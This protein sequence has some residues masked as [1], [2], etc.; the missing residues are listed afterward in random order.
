MNLRT[1]PTTTVLL[2][3]GEEEFC[4]KKKKKAINLLRQINRQFKEILDSEFCFF[5]FLFRLKRMRA[6]RT[7]SYSRSDDTSNSQCVV[8][9]LNNLKKYIKNQII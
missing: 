3:I 6:W 4:S 5:L 1:T 8:A 9:C 7:S 2:M